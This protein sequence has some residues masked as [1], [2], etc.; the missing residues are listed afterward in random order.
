MEIR[1]S[2]RNN[3]IKADSNNIKKKKTVFWSIIV[4]AAALIIAVIIG[5]A[6]LIIRKK[7]KKNEEKDEE[8]NKINDDII[9]P[10]KLTKEFEIVSNIGELNRI[11]VVQKSIEETKL[12]NNI[13][14][15]EI[16][17]KTNYDIYFISEEN[18]D[19]EN[20]LFYSKMYTGVVSIVSEC[21][22][23][24]GSDC[25]PHRLVDLT[26]ENK[27][28][29]NNIRIL[30]SVEDLKDIPISICLFNITDNNFITS[31]TCPES[32]PKSKKNEIILDLYFYR[33]PAIQ[34]ADKENDNITITIN[35]DKKNNKRYIREVNGGLCNIY[36]NTGSM[37]T[38]DMNTTTDLEGHILSYDELAITNITND[39]KN[40]YIKRKISHLIDNSKKINNLDPVKYKNSLDKILPLLEPYMKV[41]IQFTTDDFIDLYNLVQDKSKSPKKTYIQKKKK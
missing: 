6:I 37:C 34:R 13:I 24:D 36:N 22:S 10:I 14:T 15:T 30:D 23:S 18:S 17:R 35:D 29:S 3:I 2:E 20:K 26:A 11:S 1:H 4:T 9:K 33:P 39:E 19:E 16:E 8:T 38:T 27:D 40:S 25:Q 32:F 28:N 31:L 5:I 12:N 21:I 7:N 41:D